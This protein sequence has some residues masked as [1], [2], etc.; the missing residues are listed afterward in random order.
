M[1]FDNT[2][3][4]D[5]R[6]R[7]PLPPPKPEPKGSAWSAIPRAVAG[8]AA[9]MFGQAEQALQIRGM[10]ERRAADDPIR[11]E[12]EKSQRARDELSAAAIDYERSLRPD[13]STASTAEQV[14]YGLTKGLTKAIGSVATFGPAAGAGVFGGSEA[15]AAYDDLTREGVDSATAGKAAAVAGV[16]NAAGV[17]LPMAG[18]TLKATAGL[19]AIGGPGSF[20]AQQALTREILN[21]ANYS[22]IAAKYDPFDP[23][24]LSLS[25]LIPLPFAGAGALRNIRAAKAAKATD[26]APMATPAVPDA[27]PVASVADTVPVAE[28]VRAAE[29][30]PE[31]VPQE[32]IDAAMVHNLTV[33]QDAAEAA[34][35]AD[36][37]ARAPEAMP[38]QDVPQVA[39]AAEVP[40]VRAEPAAPNLGALNDAYATARTALDAEKA[41]KTA[42]AAAQRIALYPPVSSVGDVSVGGASL[43]PRPIAEGRRLYRETNK[44]GLYDLLMAEHQPHPLRVFVAD[45]KEIAIGQGDNTGIKVTFRPDSLS[46]ERHIKPASDGVSAQEYVTDIAAPRAVESIEIPT[47]AIRD[48]RGLVKNRLENFDRTDLPDGMTRFDRKQ[49]KIADT[50]PP[51]EVANLVAGLREAETDPRKMAALMRNLVREAAIPN[52]SPADA[53]ADAVA[54]MRSLTEADLAGTPKTQSPREVANESIRMIESRVQKLEAERADMPIRI[55]EDGQTLTVA[56]EMARVRR[57]AA[58][59]L[60][61]ELGTLDA[62]LVRVAAECALSLGA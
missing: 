6:D 52:K 13:P 53:T 39:Q 1:D 22:D 2:A 14:V 46:G 37:P 24:G 41:G 19:Y 50:P 62:D 34:R 59:G 42:D 31:P 33:L 32:A 40:P 55:T 44:E 3:A 28:P 23:V 58:E 57:E 16:V 4:L 12:R 10:E 61:D 35:V 47:A 25:A 56:D 60:D 30:A 43:E 48:L 9:Q 26:V 11:I 29:T 51:P 17:L 8:A 49:P 20:M 21:R 5:A 7:L 36:M 54:G 18:P 45:A 38:A 15:A 27:V